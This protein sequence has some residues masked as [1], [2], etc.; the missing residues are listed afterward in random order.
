MA[1]EIR[2]ATAADEA[3]WLR[4]WTEYLAFYDVQLMPGITA[5][6]WARILD[7]AGGIEMLV[8]AEAEDGG[9]TRAEGGAEAVAAA[10]G[11]LLG[12]ATWFGHPST[13]VATEDLYLEDLFVEA[14]ARGR[15]AGRAMIEALIALGRARGAARLYWHTDA[16]NA[17]ARALYDS[18]VPA[19][20]HLRYRL[21]L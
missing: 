9:A 3:E 17:R 5:R 10:G 15:G 6:T 11:R 16:R 13:W 4:L 1:I 2:A 12:F 21:P 8:A 20:G 18:F 14:A 19:D 7:P